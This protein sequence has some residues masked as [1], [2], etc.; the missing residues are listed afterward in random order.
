MRR[1]ASLLR[2]PVSLLL[3]FT[4]MLSGLVTVLAR[5]GLQASYQADLGRALGEAR[6]RLH[7]MAGAISDYESGGI[8][9]DLLRSNL[10]FSERGTAEALEPLSSMP[11]LRGTFLDEPD[12]AAHRASLALRAELDALDAVL[13][14]HAGLAQVAYRT[15]RVLGLV[16]PSGSGLTID[17]GVLANARRLWLQTYARELRRLDGDLQVQV[18]ELARW[19]AQTLPDL[20]AGGRWGEISA[21]LAQ[22]RGELQRAQDRLRALPAPPEALR[23]LTSYTNALGHLDRALFSMGA[24]V[25]G[26]APASLL[27]ADQE[28]AAY[29]TGRPEAASAIARLGDSR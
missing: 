14:Q 8:G 25:D 15:Q 26:R 21:R 9:E 22:S 3:V 12:A 29:R 1:S 11:E 6:P 17:P 19:R 23:P 7:M 10:G 13:Q 2:E 16:G 4:V 24:Y 27:S 5:E 18:D 28:L 20:A